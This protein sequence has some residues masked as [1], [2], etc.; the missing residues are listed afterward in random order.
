MTPWRR[1]SGCVSSWRSWPGPAPAR[2]GRL[3]RP[4]ARSA[5]PRARSPDRGRPDRPRRRNPGR[6]TGRPG[7]RTRRRCSCPP[8]SSTR[9][10]ALNRPHP[11]P[12]REPPGDLAPV[13]GA[14]SPAAWGSGCTGRTAPEPDRVDPER[15]A[16]ATPALLLNAQT[17]VLQH[18]IRPRC[19][20]TISTAV[21]PRRCAPC[22][23]R[24]PRHPGLMTQNRPLLA[25]T[26]R[27]QAQ[28]P[29]NLGHVSQVR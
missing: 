29:K 18:S 27:S 19:L 12:L 25:R 1:G 10:H 21:A 8:S 23:R 24:S 20:A 2:A 6:N 16:S 28:P 3:R 5:P 13:A 14:S 7:H 9:Q 15:P 26:S 4:E 17:Q 22:G 11:A